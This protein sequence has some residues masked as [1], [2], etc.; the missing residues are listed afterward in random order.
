MAEQADMATHPDIVAMRDRYDMASATPVAGVVEGLTLLA[1]IYLAASPWIAGFRGTAAISGSDL[2]TGSALVLLAAGLSVTYGRLHSI[3]WVVPVIGVWT[4][5]AP[6]AVAG[7]AHT[8]R[9]IWSNAVA[10]GAVVVLGALM[11]FIGAARARKT[12]G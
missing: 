6:W 10:G 4:I 11:M 7:G 8:M 12:G 5:V 1:A 2:I 3:N 9:I